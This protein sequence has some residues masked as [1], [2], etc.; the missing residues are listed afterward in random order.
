MKILLVACLS[1]GFVCGSFLRSHG[2]GTVSFVN[3]T[4]TFI[5]TNAAALGGGSG[6]TA[7]APNGFR[8][9]L[10]TAPLGTT[11]GDL[12]SGTWTFT[13]VYAT[14]TTLSSG[15]RLNGGQGIA[16]LTGWPPGVT[17]S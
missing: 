6:V 2:Q 15:G 5:S 13:G 10:F 14:N 16:T 4:S 9:A 7:S 17:N 8:Y 1:S 3:S 11:N 12:C